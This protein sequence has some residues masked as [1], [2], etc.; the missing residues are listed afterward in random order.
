M[1]ANSY[2]PARKRGRLAPV[3]FA[4]AVLRSRELSKMVEW[5]RTVLEADIQFS[6][7]F[8]AFLTYD[9]EHHRLAIVQRPD[10]VDR[11][12][13]AAG[14]E[15]L[16]YAYADLG[17]LVATYERLKSA[18][19][20][21]VRTIN[22]GPTTSMYYRDPDGNQVELQVDNFDTADECHAW[23]RSREFAENPI[24]VVFDPDELVAKF[25][26]GVPESD[27]KRRGYLQSERPSASAAEGAIR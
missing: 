8:L 9:E 18:G 20:V 24:G 16:A 23:F 19:I 27:L 2:I 17:E 26:V 14:L 4:H 10:T 1:S 5:Y 25:N 13:N 6:N 21:P 3:R 22:H 11:V 15:H 12:P 7:E